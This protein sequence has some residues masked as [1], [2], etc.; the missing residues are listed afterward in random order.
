MDDTTPPPI[1]RFSSRRGRLDRSFLTARLQGARAY[2]RI[3][4]YFSSSMLE[5]AGEALESVAGKIRVVCNSG[6][7]PR[8]VETARAAQAAL[9]QEWCASRP[10]G[11]VES[12]GD[13]ARSRFARLFDYLTTGR[14][15]VRVLPDEKFGLVHGKAGVVTLADGR[16]TS[17]LGSV[18]ETLS[19]WRINYELLW[20]DPS[21]EAVAWVQEE[22]DALWG[23]PA[24]LPLADFI[25]EDVGRI[26]ARRVIPTVEAWRNPPDSVPIDPASALIETPVYR[27]QVGLW[28][29][30]KSFVKL[31][32][33]AHTGPYKQA[34]F[35]L[36]DQVGLGK[37]IQLAM[38]AQLVALVGTRPILILAPKTLI[39][40]W[41]D[42]MND[43]LDMP[44]AVWNGR[45]WV[46]EQ[47]IEY[48]AVGPE[49][50]RRCPRR[51]G[52]VS[53]GLISRKSAAGELLKSAYYD[54]V[55]VD[56]AHRARRTNLQPG[57]E[58]EYPEPN[59]LLAFLLAISPRTRSL[60]LAT[61]TPVQMNP[62]EA[63]DLLLV[64]AGK[65][66][67]VL[68]NTF[69]KWRD[70]AWALDLVTG[71]KPFPGDL[72][73]I[74]EW[75][76]N[77]LP[78]KAEDNDFLN[79]RRSLG[80]DDTRAVADGGD[81]G[82]L[83]PPDQ[84][85]LRNLAPRFFREHNPFIR[86][87]V[88]RT[89]KHLEE[90]R[91]ESGEPYLKPIEVRLHGEGDAEAIALPPYLEEAYHTAE[92][93]TT[94][95]ARRVKSAGFLKTMI[96]RRLGSSIEAGRSTAEKLLGVWE[97][98]DAAEDDDTGDDVGPVEA[99]E[100]SKSLTDPERGVLRRLVAALEANQERDPKYAVVRDC[101]VVRHWLD[102]G[103]IIFSQYYDSIRWLAETL[104]ADLPTTL[105]GVYAGANRSGLFRDGR[106]E[107]ATRDRLKAL[108][109][110]GE[111]RLLLGTEAASEGL[112]LQ[113]LGTLINLDLPWNPTRLEQRKG[114]IQR[115]GQ[116]HDA[117]DIYNMRYKG[118]VED[119]VHHLLSSRLREIFHLFGQ[120]PDVLED[121]WVDVALGAKE[122]AKALIDA[123]PQRHPFEIRYQQVEKVNWESC[124]RVLDRKAKWDCLRQGWS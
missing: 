122:K 87:I 90:R 104:A 107:R 59:N 13:A 61:A 83:R 114:R 95:V 20:E 92:E 98:D 91:D 5:V 28:E 106:F 39:W 12:G 112:N 70:P 54:C 89:R 115:I 85:R 73:D 60:L 36:A 38:V 9:R 101:L 17:F 96:L 68:G 35:V 111:L 66:K 116:V 120:I 102:R 23:S 7:H 94:L 21:P 77:P 2:D 25:V 67:H 31:A 72:E 103:C 93:F 78:P 45:Q 40:Q 58:N 113:A 51:V 64:L 29:H 123:V 30:Q 63:W 42:E 105:I 24:A 27:E 8:D 108:V 49:G 33:D 47:G 52:V 4:G 109:R 44:S 11:L 37:T 53:T 1:Q 48:P 110:S 124:A 14:L 16:K 97:N 50:I 3:A 18:N 65:E 75:V 46:D 71:K 62:V 6:L 41:Q 117:I 82:K 10:E 22:F 86:H 74:W 118:S 121:V 43:L 57:C 79:L 76:R 99:S 88:R 56:E 55:I 34:R 15:E 81:F 19:G 119:R 69:S 26:A 84:T 80:L 32:F 100:F